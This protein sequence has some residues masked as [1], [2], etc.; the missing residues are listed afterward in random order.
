VLGHCSDSPQ[1]INV[2][3][4]ATKEMMEGTEDLIRGR[5]YNVDDVRFDRWAGL[6][7]VRRGHPGRRGSMRHPKRILLFTR[8]TLPE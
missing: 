1:R 3:G 4:A 8:A 6:T 7:S 5:K 2:L